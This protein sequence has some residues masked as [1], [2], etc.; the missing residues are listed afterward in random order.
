LSLFAPLPEGL[1]MPVFR[2]LPHSLQKI[3]WR[4]RA[5]VILTP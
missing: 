1:E 2:E 4:C 5:T 3:I